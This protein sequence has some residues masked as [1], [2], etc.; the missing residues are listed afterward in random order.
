LKLGDRG[1]LV[2]ELNIRLTGFG[3]TVK[4]P[5]PLNEFTSKTESAVRQFQRDYMEVPETGKVCG[6]FLKALDDFRARF[7][8]DL[9]KMRCPCGHCHGFGNG[10]TTPGPSGCSATQRTP[11]LIPEQSTPAC[12]ARSSGD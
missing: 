3:G 4:A 6:P 12:I 1:A 9:T 2:E 11:I 8:I 7:P 5:T 10:Y